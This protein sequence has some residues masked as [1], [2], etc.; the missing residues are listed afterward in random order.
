LL[1][2]VNYLFNIYI[3]II[4][5]IY[6]LQNKPTNAIRCFR[7]ALIKDPVNYVAYEGLV[8]SYS[9]LNKP[10]EAYIIAKKASETMPKS[11]RLLTLL[12]KTFTIDIELKDKVCSFS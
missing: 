5:N 8:D 11:A 10:A 7:A 3:Y 1:I 6:L 12:G 2:R 4:G 9:Y